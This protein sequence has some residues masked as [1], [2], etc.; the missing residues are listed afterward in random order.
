MSST[1]EWIVVGLVRATLGLALAA[2]AVE[3]AV[4]WLGLREPRVERWAWFFVLAQGI[5]LVPASIPV[6]VPARPR[7]TTPSGRTEAP[8]PRG[9]ALDDRTISRLLP[10]HRPDRPIRQAFERRPE[11]VVSSRRL[12]PERFAPSWAVVVLTAWAVGVGVLTAV[13][14]LRY[15]AFVLRLRAARPAGPEWEVPWRQML[16]E[17]GIVARIPL[18]VSRDV[19]PAL[20]RVPGGY[21]LVVPETLW[22]GLSPDERA[23]VLRH[24]LAHYRRGD[25][26]TALLA[27][28]LTTVHWFNPL[29][30]RAVSRFEAQAEFLCDRESATEDPVTFA[31]TLLRLGEG[32][33]AHVAA[34][35]SA[36]AGELFERIERLLVDAPRPAWWRRA[37]PIGVAVLALGASG[38]RLRAVAMPYGGEGEG[39]G[40]G[41]TT[42]RQPLPSRA[43][44]RL[45]TDDLRTRD[46]IMDLAFSPDGRL[47][48]AAPAN[49]SPPTV[50]VFDART[51]H[52]V[53]RVVTPDAPREI[54]WIKCLAFSPDGTKLAWGE[55][56]G[57]VAIWDLAADRQLYRGKLHGGKSKADGFTPVND[58]AFSPDGALVASAGDDGDVQLRRVARL[59]E[60]CRTFATTEA[61]ASP[62]RGVGAWTPVLGDR[63]QCLAFTPDGT[64]LVVGTGASATAIVWRVEDG[65]L[66]RQT[67]RVIDEGSSNP[68][69]KSVSITPDGRR[70]LT[71]GQVNLTN[72]QMKVRREGTGV[73]VRLWDIESGEPI[74]DLLGELGVGEGY[75]ALSRDG[76]HVAVADQNRLRILDIETGKPERTIPVPGTRGGPPAFSPDGT[77]VAL[78]L[79]NSVALFETQTGRSL[80]HDARTPVGN[81]ASAAWSPS[82]DRI[83]TGHGDGGAGRGDGGIRV[84]DAGTGALLWHQ[85]LA[86]VVTRRGV[87]AHPVFVAFSRDGRR[88]VAAGR[89]D[90][91]EEDPGVVAIYEATTGHPIRKVHTPEIRAAAFAPDRGTIAVLTSSGGGAD[92][93]EAIGIEVETG[94]ILYSTRPDRTRG[95][96]WEVR[97]MGFRADSSQF[98]VAMDNADVIAF[99]ALRGKVLERFLADDRTAERKKEDPFATPRLA[100]VAFSSD[101][102][103]LVS[104]SSKKISVWDVAS[105][106]LKTQF[107]DPFK[108]G[109]NLALSPDGRTL[110]ASESPAPGGVFEED[111]I[112]LF[113]LERGA[114]LLTLDPGDDRAGTL[115]FSPDGT[116]LFSGF[117]RGSGV[118]WDIRP[119]AAEQAPGNP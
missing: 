53:R 42:S 55:I 103:R 11:D 51:G 6:S 34:G 10:R 84:W 119:G 50:D 7:A 74:R 76:R 106:R 54:A 116:K 18:F 43:L 2:L 52:L 91:P 29:A 62:V 100:R 37:I 39:P 111:T 79:E 27:R 60:P 96:Y 14:V 92:D 75:A 64:R 49:A 5:V 22:A 94:R 68:G 15:R 105:G 23:P 99:D 89:R 102:R 108:R 69:L 80:L 4:R 19:G 38:V 115:V 113:D 101:G 12:R 114:V 95:R 25:L 41:V 93:S 72:E 63:A 35:M 78:P 73:E 70:I 45:G 17:R 21:R 65:R 57:F 66:L 33:R 87:S 44:L 85:I 97:A 88:V 28:A 82:G 47:V 13:G 77:I 104:S 26:G 98:D 117:R 109:A 58:V 112:R 30:W 83:V 46:V 20:C 67:R 31:R 59:S 110:A 3:A 86:P 56:G 61:L 8:S 81:V 90:D 1:S 32:P 24:E 71:A 9:S 48:A 16:R 107:P 40:R 118:I 36:G